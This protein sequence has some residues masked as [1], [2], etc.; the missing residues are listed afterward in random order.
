MTASTEVDGGFTPEILASGY[1]G[2]VA[3]TGS[4]L[5]NRPSLKTSSRSTHGSGPLRIAFSVKI[6]GTTGFGIW[7][8]GPD[9][10]DGTA[11]DLT[12]WTSAP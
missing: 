6:Y 5:K 8:A 10:V 7:S 2:F 1:R 9:G 11:D 12:S 4:L 3:M